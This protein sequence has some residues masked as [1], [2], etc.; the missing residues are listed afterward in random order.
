MTGEVITPTGASILRTL[1]RP[2]NAGKPPRHE[3]IGEQVTSTAKE[4]Y[5]LVFPSV[6]TV[7]VGAGSR[8]PPDYPNICRLFLA[9]PAPQS[10]YVVSQLII[11]EANIDDM[12][13]EVAGHV[14]ELLVGSEGVL[15]VWYTSIQMKKNRPAIK[16]SVLVTFEYAD[17]IQ[18]LIFAESTTI[19]IRRSYVDRTAL[20]RKFED[21]Q[22]SFG[23]VTMKL[24]FLDGELLNAS[25]EYDKVREVARE[26]GVPWKIVADE[27]KAKH[28]KA[29][30]H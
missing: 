4:N 13:G 22:T 6:E 23:L 28:L 12:S 25:P 30:L 1:V 17:K 11:L 24:A 20:L 7:G 18:R 26:A 29:S 9:R 15:D 10:Q 8:N 5:N 27:A 2:E 19:G 14:M 21:V 3:W 16:L